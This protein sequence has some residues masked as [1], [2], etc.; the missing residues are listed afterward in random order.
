MC[1]KKIFIYPKSGIKS[2]NQFLI[3]YFGLSNI[4]KGRN[5]TDKNNHKQKNPIS[6]TI[7]MKCDIITKSTKNAKYPTC[8]T[9]R[10]K[11]DEKCLIILIF[12]LVRLR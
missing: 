1:H 9:I 5:N 8:E 7:C 3:R 12:I 2:L 11:G 10:K 6:L 4:E